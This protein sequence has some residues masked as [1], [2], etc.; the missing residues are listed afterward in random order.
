MEGTSEVSNFKKLNVRVFEEHNFKDPL[1]LI[2]DIL[3][4]ILI[5]GST[6]L[7]FDEAFSMAISHNT[8]EI[9]NIVFFIFFLIEW[10]SSLYTADAIWPELGPIKSRI[11]WIFSL[12]SIV[13]II[14]FIILVL[15]IIPD[16]I[17]DDIMRKLFLIKVVRLYKLVK[18][19]VAYYRIKKGIAH[20]A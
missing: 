17:P 8:A 20:H 3:Y 15:N 1:C 13:D 18:Y 11:K 6:A 10:V 14:C 4:I 7:V 9:L 16:L 19:P 5:L 12:E 2:F